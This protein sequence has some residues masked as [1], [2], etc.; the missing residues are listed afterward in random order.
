MNRLED[1][2]VERHVPSGHVCVWIFG[3]S[4]D[5]VALWFKSSGNEQGFYWYATGCIFVSLLFYLAI[6]DTKLNSKMSRHV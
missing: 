6:P 5:S 4:V 3:G 1:G 2:F